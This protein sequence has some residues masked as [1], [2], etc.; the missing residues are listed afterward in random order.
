M[1]DRR[2][3]SSRQKFALTTFLIDEDIMLQIL[4]NLIFDGCYT[5]NSYRCPHVIRLNDTEG[6]LTENYY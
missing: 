6:L 4:N 3:Y 1:I 2:K 5:S